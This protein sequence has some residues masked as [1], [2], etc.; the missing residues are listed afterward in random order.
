[1][2]KI[3]KPNTILPKLSGDGGTATVKLRQL[4]EA[5]VIA[6][7]TG[8]KKFLIEK[9]IYGH[10][11]VKRA[12]KDAQHDKCCFC[13]RKTEVGD[14]EHYRGKGGYQQDEN[15]AL[16]FPGYYWLAYDWE[17]LFFSCETCNRSY[18]RNFFPLENPDERAK[19]HLDDLSLER[20]IIINPAVDDPEEFIEFYGHHP[21]AINGNRKGSETIKR[22]GLERPFMNDRRR[23]HYL[24]LKGIFQAS[25]EASLT[26]TQ[27]DGFYALLADAAKSES[28]YAAMIRCAIR[29][30]FKY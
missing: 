8:A 6:Y 30:D 15:E 21:K 14:V 1:M 29:Q 27:R 13:E 19:S 4:Y 9:R 26:Q 16:Q 5:D 2:V 17:N 20:P 10:E 11:T 18:K 22:T 3:E 23:N 28:E 25:K 7:S 24:I 12:L